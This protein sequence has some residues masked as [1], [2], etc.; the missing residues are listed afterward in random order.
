MTASWAPCPATQPRA[1]RSGFTLIEVLGAV[2]LTSLVLA[3]AVGMFLNLS[4]ASTSAVEMMRENLRATAVLDR[5]SRD[6]SGASLLT[7]PEEVDP[8]VHPWYFT[9]ESQNTFGGA[10]AVKFISR[11]QRPKVSAYHASDLAQVAYFTAIEDDGSMTLYRWTSPSLSASY[12]PGFPTPD[13]PGS[14]V[15]AEGLRGVQFRFRSEEGEWV[16][17]WDSTQLVQ[18]S[19]LPTAVEVNVYG[20]G[21]ETEEEL[22]DDQLPVHSQQILIP[23]RPIDLAKMIQ[24]YATAQQAAL[25]GA[26]ADGTDEDDVE[27]DENGNPIPTDP[28]VL[29]EG[30]SVADCVRANLDTCNAQFG[31]ENCLV[32]SNINNLPVAGFGVALPP[33]WN[34]R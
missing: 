6:L 10:D 25:A 26:G 15:L 3:V 21:R 30:M 2:F 24:D 32:W 7:R 23:Q 1:A 28:E 17:E 5:I 8:L 16:D 9:A 29:G 13:T 27:L 19:Q 18:S 14:F 34:C 12:D 31:R 20:F 4:N 22:P 11:S 33:Q